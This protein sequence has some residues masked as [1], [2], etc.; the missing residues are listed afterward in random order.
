MRVTLEMQYLGLSTGATSLNDVSLLVSV[1]QEG[2][3][4]IA[5][6]NSSSFSLDDLTDRAVLVFVLPQVPSNQVSTYFG[7]VPPGT[8]ILRVGST[9]R[10]DVARMNVV[11]L[12]RTPPA[13]ALIEGSRVPSSTGRVVI[14]TLTNFIA[15][16][17][18]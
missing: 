8:A 1:I 7:Q 5:T 13:L 4:G 18:W 11:A 12:P 6:L 10:F 9:S 2:F 14:V 3:N 16:C 17:L 15:V